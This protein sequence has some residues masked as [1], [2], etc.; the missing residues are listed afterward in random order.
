MDLLHPACSNLLYVL[1]Y[2]FDGTINRVNFIYASLVLTLF[3]IQMLHR[4]YF[5]RPTRVSA[6]PQLTHSST[7][8]DHSPHTNTTQGLFS[9]GH[10]VHRHQPLHWR[11][12]GCVSPLHQRRGLGMGHLLPAHDSGG[13]RDG[14]R[15]RVYV[16][17]VKG[18]IEKVGVEGVGGAQEGR[19]VDLGPVARSVSRTHTLKSTTFH[20]SNTQVGEQS[21]ARLWI[22]C[23]LDPPHPLHG[24]HFCLAFHPVAF[25]IWVG[26][27]GK[28]K[29]SPVQIKSTHT[30]NE[31]ESIKAPCKDNQTKEL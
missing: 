15:L 29:G 11:L 12:P 31:K 7:K 6:S 30:K 10:D 1:I 24:G 18:R 8:P 2:S 19:V 20:F 16:S 3:F 17:T 22:F 5:Y 9:R 21:L 28:G 4:I 26:G 23:A 13:D 25:L 14:G 27:Q